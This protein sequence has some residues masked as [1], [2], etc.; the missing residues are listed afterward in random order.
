[1]KKFGLKLL[2]MGVL[3]AFLGVGYGVDTTYAANDSTY[4]ATEV[5]N[6]DIKDYANGNFYNILNATLTFEKNEENVISDFE[7]GEPFLLLDKDSNLESYYFPVK[8]A[9]EIV[10]TYVLSKD[11][12]SNIFGQMSKFL[13]EELQ[14][15]SEENVTDVNNPITL[16]SEKGDIY[17]SLKNERTLIY[18]SPGKT[19]SLTND[20]TDEDITNFSEN[21]IDIAEN[22]D[23]SI[24]IMSRA[25]VSSDANHVM[26]DFKITETQGDQ[27]WCAAYVAAAALRNKKNPIGVSAYGMMK[28]TFPKLSDKQLFDTAISREQ[29]KSFANKNG[30]YPTITNGPLSK[31]QVRQQLKNS[32]AVYAG[33][34][35]TGAYKGGRHAW[36]IY[37]WVTYGPGIDV[38]YAWN[39]WNSYP[40]TMDAN[41]NTLNVP[42]GS[43]KWDVSMS[44]W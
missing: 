38:Y 16:F 23:Y 3:I 29:I 41:S 37:G 31:G 17:Y 25:N 15:I 21:V 39:P 4:I 8:N 20:V 27:P 33:G 1:M 34:P 43:F 22:E 12:N 18:E 24:P 32:S 44:G 5:V 9:G 36:D 40:V 19:K 7:L 10:Y 30:S 2:S 35:G 6:D 11:E 26:I 42:G 28:M 14:K 13:A